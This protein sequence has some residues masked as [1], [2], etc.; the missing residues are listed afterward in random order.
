MRDICPHR[1]APLSAGRLVEKPGEGETI[2]CPYHGWRFRPDGVCAAIPSLVEDQAYETD[3]IRVRS[4]PVRES[5]GMVFVWVASD[6]RN[7]TPSRTRSR[8]SFPAWSAA[9]RNW[10]NGWISTAI[11]TT[12]SSA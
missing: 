4:Y 3:R 10:S 9:R 1:A 11:S 7:R 12:R 2:E 5:Q 8:R 6:P